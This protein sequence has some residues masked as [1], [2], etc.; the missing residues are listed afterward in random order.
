[1]APELVELVVTDQ[2]V[3]P[4]L[5]TLNPEGAYFAAEINAEVVGTIDIRKPNLLGQCIVEP[6][7]VRPDRHGQG[8]GTRLWNHAEDA[9]VG[10]GG[11]LIGAWSIVAN[12]AARSFY[13]ARGCNPIGERDLVVGTTTFKCEFLA[14][15]IG[16][17][18]LPIGSLG[19]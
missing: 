17:P 1:M 11:R 19:A 16:P 3:I 9:A 5:S 8:V 10:W 4:W 15:S 2:V 13:L 14:K 7:M 6:L 12:T 18:R